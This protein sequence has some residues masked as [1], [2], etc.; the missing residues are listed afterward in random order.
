M[1]CNM[2]ACLEERVVY[3]VKE[4]KGRFTVLKSN[5]ANTVVILKCKLPVV[6]KSSFIPPNSL[7][8]F[9]TI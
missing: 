8:C 4:A 9:S 2:L 6:G 7:H 1:S 3:G 5:C